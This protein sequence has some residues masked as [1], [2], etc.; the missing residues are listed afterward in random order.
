MIGWL[1]KLLHIHRW[2]LWPYM[3]RQGHY[4]VRCR[5]GETKMVPKP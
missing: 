3:G 5:C 2:Q 1:K 4:C